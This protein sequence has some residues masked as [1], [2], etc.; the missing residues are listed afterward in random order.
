M[1]THLLTLISEIIFATDEA[2]SDT[3]LTCFCEVPDVPKMARTGEFTALHS[4]SKSPLSV[5]DSNSICIAT[6]ND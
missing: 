5:L 1:V 2:L 4:C 6:G 3:L